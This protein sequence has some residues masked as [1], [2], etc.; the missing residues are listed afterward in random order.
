MTT[1]NRTAL[2]IG[3]GIAGPAAALF[4][5]RAGIEATIYEAQ[6]APDDFAG[7]FLT[8]AANGM[9]V[10]QTL[11]VEAEVATAGFATPRLVMWS[12]SGKRL[13]EV[14]VGPSTEQGTTSTTVRRGVL[15]RILREKALRQGIEIEF[16]KRLTSVDV[17]GQQVTAH[18]E[19]GRS[20]TGDFLVGCDGIHSA[21]RRFVDACAPRP[22][23]TGLISGGG[24]AQ[25]AALPAPLA[26]MPNTMHMI[27]GQRAFFGYLVQP[28]GD[29]Y[30]FENHEY[31]GEPRRSTLE[32]T[33]QRQWR[34]TLLHLHSAD[35]PR[36][37]DIVRATDKIGMYPIYDMPT[38]PR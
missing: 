2:V 23:Y 16:G 28:S 4:L 36:I 30:W 38:V 20:A 29:I 33:P 10:L 15:Q 7:L 6:P 13:G 37:G 5:Q 25:N 8:V 14:R 19:D 11:G 9:H 17:V 27:F 1:K 26:P 21:T 18:F 12:S 31:P 3:C 22:T 34:E 35:Q 24:F 32:A